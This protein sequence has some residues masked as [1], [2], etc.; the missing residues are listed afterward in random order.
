M[1]FKF[2]ASLALLSVFA[3]GA[4]AVRADEIEIPKT[5]INYAAL[6][7]LGWK[8][9]CQAYTFRE[10][11]LFETID[12]LKSLDI[13]YIELYPG[14][15]LS[16]EH[17][18]LI[19]WNLS[20]ERMAEL[21]KK[22]DEAKI[23]VTNFGVT[24]LTNDEKQCRQ[25]FD[26]AKK[27][28]C[29]TVVS[30]PP[31]EAF[32]LVDRLANEYQINVAIHDHPKPSTYWNPDFVLKA[33]EGRSNRIGSCSDVGHWLRSGLVPLDCI[34][35]LKGH[36]ISLH[37]KDINQE[38]HDVPWGTGEC[39][40]A[41][42]M[43]EVQ[44]Q[45]IHPVFSAEYEINHGNELIANVAK[46]YNY[47]SDVATVLAQEMDA[48]KAGDQL[49]KPVAENKLTKSERQA[50]W[51]LLFDGKTTTGWRTYHKPTLSNGWQVVNG[52]LT[53]VEPG[54][55][56]VMTVDEFSDFDLELDFIIPAQGNSGVIYRCDE[57]YA[58]CWQTGVECQIIDNAWKAGLE[59]GQKCGAAYEIVPPFKDAANPVGEWNH[60][61]IVANGPHVEHWLNGEKVAEYEQGSPEFKDIVSKAKFNKFP[62]FGTLMKGHIC[63]QDHGANVQ[64][65][66]IKIRE[67]K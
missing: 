5:H 30:E 20:N 40:I 36:I 9:G 64:F 56:D 46:S 48:P 27:L 54:H 59:P 29:G 47:F 17:P 49:I 38:M 6:D 8:L 7:K 63:L 52:I 42:I 13:H 37:F 21:H 3:L 25:T 32:E 14:Q 43:R 53:C 41:G 24:P 34:K 23:K 39:N 15:K 65:K 28:G 50:G 10:F 12:I 66:N 58:T 19:D 35:K 18:D 1:R 26:F 51:K 44:Q 61:R 22:L 33:C 55:G 62:K 4:L 31:A 2:K 16:K 45:G 57:T 67:I 11:T 60:L